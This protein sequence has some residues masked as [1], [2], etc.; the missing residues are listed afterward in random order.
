MGTVPPRGP[1]DV[2]SRL[3]EKLHSRMDGYSES[4]KYFADKF[5]KTFIIHK[6]VSLVRDFV[7]KFLNSE[8]GCGPIDSTTFASNTRKF[9][10]R[11]KEEKITD[12]IRGLES[13]PHGSRV[14]I[15]NNPVNA[16]ECVFRTLSLAYYC[17]FFVIYMAHQER[18]PVSCEKITL[19]QK[20]CLSFIYE[21]PE[22]FFV[23]F[24][25]S[26]ILVAQVYLAF[27]K[28]GII[29]LEKIDSKT[30]LQNVFMSLCAE[31]CKQILI[32]GEIN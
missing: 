22:P 2:K 19:M 6:E 27:S 9:L 24:E 1:G 17:I 8:I 12:E 11:F 14:V 21:F 15:I 25:K 20:V 13:L 28:E 30:R 16:Y 23:A 4:A 32:N 10:A 18:K 31:I 7:I 26:S 3:V 5:N 29:K